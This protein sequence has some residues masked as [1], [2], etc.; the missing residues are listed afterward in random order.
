MY[1]IAI[2]CPCG[3][4]DAALLTQLLLDDLVVRERDAALVHLAVA[5][6]VDE[7]AHG[8]QVRVAERDVRRNLRPSKF[9]ELR[10]NPQCL[11]FSYSGF[12]SN[13]QKIQ[14]IQESQHL[15]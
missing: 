5:A 3:T 4:V 11:T 7:L 15:D 10:S 6:L 14:R 13:C 1:N 8:L 9:E 12:F 2:A